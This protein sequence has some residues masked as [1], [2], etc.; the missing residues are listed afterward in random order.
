MEIS[1][2]QYQQPAYRRSRLAYHME[3]AF[4]YMGTLLV[5]DAYL[6]KVLTAAG[7]SDDLIGIISTLVSL[8]SLVGLFSILMMTRLRQLKR[9]VIVFQTVSGLFFMLT[10]LVPLLPVSHTVRVLLIFLAIGGGYF[11]RCL[12]STIYYRWANSYVNPAGLGKYSSVK[13]MI[14][15]LS[16]IVFTLWAGLTMDRFEEAGDLKSAFL[17]M[18]G[19]I[20]LLSLLSFLSLTA[21]EKDSGEST[22]RMHRPLSEVWRETMGNKAFRKIV[23][24][25]ALADV[26]KYITLGFLGTFKTNDLGMSVGTVQWINT[27]AN[28]CRFA[29]SI[30]FGVYSDHKGYQKG[31]RLGLLLSV[32]AFAFSA[33]TTLRTVWMVIPF[34]ILFN[35]SLAGTN[36]NGT[37]LCYTCVQQDC[38]IQAMAI[39]TAVCGVSGFLASLAASRVLAAIQAAGNQVL[40]VPMY[41][42]QFLSAVSAVLLLIAYFAAGT[43]KGEK[44]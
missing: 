26:A 42:Q 18:A 24:I 29:V 20:L 33:L 2:T 37:N 12:V 28:L 39:R 14:S 21:I 15:L 35:V 13:E 25:T 16:G 43:M 30:P 36:S 4:A 40:G 5:S 7:L 41:G 38:L 6:A 9:T 10:F 11:C 1:E 23:L 44:R 31:Y 8:G 3:C 19:V 17:L 22:G 32:I 27:A 34:T